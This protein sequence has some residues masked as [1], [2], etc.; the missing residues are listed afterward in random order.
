MVTPQLLVNAIDELLLLQ[1]GKELGLR[2]GDDQF[3]ASS[4]TSA[5]SSISRRR[6]FRQRRCA[7]EDMTRTTCGS[8]WRAGC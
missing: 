3:K 6:S 8:S 7:Q 2:L 1:R 5:K 4:P